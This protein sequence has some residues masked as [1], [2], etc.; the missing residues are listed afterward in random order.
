[1]FGANVTQLNAAFDPATAGTTTITV[2]TPAGFD[3][4]SAQRQ[5]TATVTAPTISV[6]TNPRIG[7]DLQQSFGIALTTAP[8]SAVD[9]VVT[10]GSSAIARVSD[11]A[12][13]LGGTSVSFTGV[14]NTTA[15]AI[16]LQG[17]QQ[18]TTTLTVTAAGYVTNTQTIS[19]DPSGFIIAG[20]GGLNTNTFASNVTVTIASARLEP[21]TLA[22]N[23]GNA[24]PVRAGAV[25]DVP[26]T[27]S[28]PGVGTITVSPVS[29]GTN[30]GFL[31]TAFDPLTAGTTT[32]TVGT[33]AGFDTPANSRQAAANV[34]APAINV[35]TN[36]RI[37]EDLQ[38]SFPITLGITPPNPVDITVAITSGTIARVSDSA[39]LLGGTT[40]TFPG[41]T[42]T[43][44][45]TIVLQGMQQGTTTMIV[46]APGYATSVQ[47][48]SVDPSGFIFF[49]TTGITTT[50][51]AGNTNM[52]VAAARLNPVTLDGDATTVQGVRAGLTVAVSF[53]SSNPAVGVMTVNPLSFGANASVLTTQ[54][55]PVAPGSTTIAVVPPPGFD[56]PNALRQIA[57]TVNP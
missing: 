47:T 15:R 29:F 12:T 34:T 46:S 56:T 36:P 28:D 8:P 6:P 42:N 22:F 45:R 39:T 18:G 30:V 41:V 49:G 14:A 19:V 17:L 48:V 16:F 13:A 1:M 11:T 44:A 50:A 7:E 43:S 37:G 27:S 26:V 57:V 21:G 5:I 23:L 24:Q 4:P 52:S 31:N 10:V 2:E 33:P 38:Q 20:T 9:I 51:S 55:D 25:V 35:P 54:F 3:T 53:T 32:I 40:V